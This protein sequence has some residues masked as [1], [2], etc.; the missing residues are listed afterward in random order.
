MKTKK[1]KKVMWLMVLA[2]GVIA[3]QPAAHAVPYMQLGFYDQVDPS[4][5]PFFIDD[6][7]VGDINPLVGAVTFLSFL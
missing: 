5:V 6:N 7:G 3:F 1:F 2:L 4:A